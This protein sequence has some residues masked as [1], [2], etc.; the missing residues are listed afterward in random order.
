MTTGTNILQDALAF[1]NA[2]DLDRAEECYRRILACEPENSTILHLAYNNIAMVL[3][4]QGRCSQAVEYYRRAARLAPD[5]AE[6]HFNLAN[7]LRVDNRFE[8]AAVSYNQALEVRPDYAEAHNNLAITLREQGK[9]EQAV[10]CYENAIRC[11]PRC[12]AFYSNL[13]SLLQRQGRI[14]EAVFNCERAVGLAPDSPEV[15][16]NLG[17]ALRDAGR[18]DEAI[19]QNDLAIRLRPDYAEA[20]WNQAVACLL[21]GDFNKGWKEFEWRRKTNWHVS[22]YPHKHQNPRWDGK[23][24]AGK[25]LLVHCEQGVGDCI[26][27]VRYLPLVKARGGTVVFEAWKSLHGL[28]QDFDGID[29]LT[30]LSFGGESRAQFDYHVSIMDLPGVF[31]TVE[32]RIPDC[33]P[34]IHADPI[35][36]AKWREQLAGPHLKIGIVWAGS[37]RHSNDHNRSCRFDHFDPLTQIQ[38]VRL[39]GLQ[40]GEP[41]QQA[42]DS[43]L[44]NLGDCLEDF[45]DTAAAIENLDL[46]ISVDTAVL[47]LAGAMGKTVWALLAYAP[48]WRWMLEREDSPWYPTMRLF[49]QKKWGDW[50]SAMR[51]VAQE[52]R[53]LVD[54]RKQ[55]IIQ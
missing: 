30:E 45:T 20:H 14:Y 40:K 42:D 47:H 17:S 27:F 33:V 23:S 28:F 32:Q 6:I 36:S 21:K 5:C 22:S 52:L 10:D 19:V 13:A 43:A 4:S 50:H 41:A 26:Q 11:N 35:K 3:Q 34:Y 44:V 54:K 31:G 1:H 2:G 38:G 16:Y 29:E 15:H 48:D 51:A 53:V 46:I 12:A 25:R 49:R 24:F 18:C 9:L 8:E 37:A 39:Y 7:A 55:V